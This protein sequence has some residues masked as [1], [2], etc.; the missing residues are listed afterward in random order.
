MQNLYITV[1]TSD[2]IYVTGKKKSETSDADWNSISFVSYFFGPSTD[3]VN[4]TGFFGNKMYVS[5]KNTALNN[6]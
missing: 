6:I 2:K 5:I 4:I 1:S 3:V